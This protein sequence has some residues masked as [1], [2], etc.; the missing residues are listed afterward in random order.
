MGIIQRQTLKNNLLAYLAVAVGGYA[1]IFIYPENLELK[2]HADGLLKIA[3]LLFPFFTFG[4]SIVQVRFLPYLT[5]DKTQTASQLLTR[6]LAI[7]TAG[8]GLL[9]FF[10]FV[11]GEAT[12]GAFREAGWKLGKLDNY[13]WTIIGLTAAL[14]Y[15]STFTAYL[16]NF[17]RIAIPV[18][19]NNLLLKVGLLL[20]FLGAVYGGYYDRAG[21]TNGLIGLYFL[22]VLGLI[23]YATYLGVFRLRWGELPL[24]DKTLADMRSLAL[25]GIFGSI[26]SV[27]ATHMDTILINTLID[28]TTTSVYSFAI[29][30]TTV[31]AIP[32]KAINAIASPIVS[33]HWKAR[34]LEQLAFLYRESAAVLFAAGGFIYTGAIVCLP[35]LFHLTDKTDQLAIGYTA[36]ILLGAGQLFDQLTSINN[37]LISYTDYYRWNIVFLVLMGV[38]NAGF[39]YYCIAVLGLGLTGA[40]AATAASLCIYNLVKGGFIYWKMGIQ[41]LSTGLLYTAVLLFG[42]GLLAWFVPGPS[43]AA[44]NIIFRGGIIT[45]VFLAYLRFTDGVPPIRRMLKGGVKAMF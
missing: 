33:E 31:I 16:T 25:F 23:A 13:R 17:K 14:V 40:A 21:F 30:V 44:V 34:N 19:F 15:S 29:F 5:G 4:M 8:L 9:A 41:P 3:L 26:G 2:G 24:R 35:Y 43:G 12:A 6:S 37:T 20:I 39:T 45:V 38:L 22:T 42:A 32:Y 27:L 1:Q 18:L 7:V 36:A 10:N 11:C 28:D